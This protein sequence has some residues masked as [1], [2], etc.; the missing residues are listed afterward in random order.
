M[1]RR[2]FIKVIGGGAAAWPLAARAQQ[3]DA[4]RRIGVLM[5]FAAEDAVAQAR[6]T[7]FMQALQQLGWTK[8]RNVQI[9]IRW[10]TGDAERTRRYATELA[11]LT[12]DVIL[13]STSVSVAAL[14][15]ATRVLPIVFVQVADPVGAGFVASLGKPAGN[16]TGFTI[17]EYGMSAKWL[18]MLKEIAPHVTRAGIV[19]DPAS[20]ADIG[21]FGAIQSVAPS[22][23][24]QLSPINLDDA[25]EIERGISTF[26]HEPNRGLIVVGGA[27]AFTYREQ[28]IALAARYQLPAVYPD[29]GFI[30]AGGLISYGPDRLDDYQR[31]AGY[32]DRILKGEKPADLPVQTPTRFELVINLKTAKALGLTLP[33]PLLARANEVIE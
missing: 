20:V 4:M 3:S 23:G 19:R 14:R 16:V 5:N 33:P 27:L 9:D 17:Y 26:A 32:V 31:A 29:R 2:E 24:I 30:T 12:P 11:A 22:L 18:E 8:G 13:A 15:Q 25:S 10:T 7:A 28:I 21:M 1:R 6:V